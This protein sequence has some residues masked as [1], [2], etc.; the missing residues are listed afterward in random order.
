MYFPATTSPIKRKRWDPLDVEKPRGTLVDEDT[1]K[2]LPNEARGE[3]VEEGK[4]GSS[5][6]GAEERTQHEGE[7]NHAVACGDEGG[8]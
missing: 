7:R 2:Q 3:D 6:G 4:H 1:Q 5:L 8:K